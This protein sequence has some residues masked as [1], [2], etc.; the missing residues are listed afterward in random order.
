MNTEI[1]DTSIAR[2]LRE[3]PDFFAQHDD[4][5]EILQIPGPHGGKATSISER[6]VLGLREKLRHLENKLAELILFGEDNDAISEKVHRLGL[7]L[8]LA[9]DAAAVLRQ[10][11]AHL[12]GAFAVPHVALRLWGIASGSDS[13]EFSPVLDTLRERVSGLQQPYCVAAA[14][15]EVLAWFGDSAGHIRS[16][17]L[18]AL[19]CDGEGEAVGA[20]V[21]ASEESQR[22]YAE[23]GT[24]YLARIGEMAAA[25]LLRTLA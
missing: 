25:A 3:H 2:Y 12:D 18:I 13:V 4:L 5:L 1:D 7:D 19:R 20:L 8:L 23:M 14:D 21:L 15:Q 17:A 11:Y 24:L 9:K 10:L 6:Q 16:L 22:F